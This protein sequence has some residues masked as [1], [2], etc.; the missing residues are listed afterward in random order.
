MIRGSV[1]VWGTTGKGA[2]RNCALMADTGRLS[3]CGFPGAGQNGRERGLAKLALLL[4]GWSKSIEAAPWHLWRGRDIPT[5]PFTLVESLHNSSLTQTDSRPPPIPPH[6]VVQQM[7][8]KPAL[9]ALAVWLVCVW[10]RP[11]RVASLGG[12]QSWTCGVRWCLSRPTTLR[13]LEGANRRLS[14][15]QRLGRSPCTAWTWFLTF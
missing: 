2:R 5:M 12:H 4:V 9:M 13:E 14:R 8:R 15:Q 1:C 7:A 3:L 11:F 6:D 10:I